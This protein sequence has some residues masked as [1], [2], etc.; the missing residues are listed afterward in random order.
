[1]DWYSLSS[2]VAVNKL[3]V[4]GGL[5]NKRI[6]ESQKKYG[7]NV[8]SKPKN[9]SFLKRLFSALGEPMILILILSAC[10]TFGVNLGRLLKTGNADFIEFFGI[11][12]A[13]SVSVCITL[14]MEGSSQKA[15]DALSKMYDKVNVKVLRDKN[16]KVIS[17]EDVVVGDLIELCAGDKIVADGRLIECT[18]FSVDESALTGESVPSRKDAVSVLP[19]GSHLAERKNMVYSGSFVT[20]G[21]AKYVVTGVGNSTEIGTIANEIGKKKEISSPLEQKL[22]KLGKTITLI[23]GLVSAFIFLISIT[24]LAVTKQLTFYNAQQVFISCIVLIV[25]AVPEGLPSIVA[26]SLALNM[27]KLAKSNALIKKLIATETTGAV[28]VICSDKTG[29]LTENKMRVSA[30]CTKECCFNKTENN[31]DVLYENFCINSTADLTI[32]GGV[33]KFVG[34]GSECALLSAY[35][36]STK[37]DYK[38]LRL[39][40]KII[41]RMPFSSEEKRMETLVSKNDY[42]RLYVKGAPEVILGRCGLSDSEIKVISDKIQDYEKQCKR[43]LCFAHMDGFDTTVGSKNLTFDGFAVISDNIRK[44]VFKAVKDAKKAGIEIKIL[45][46]DNIVTAIAIARE[47]GIILDDK[48]AVLASDIDKISDSELKRIL[49]NVKVIARS[50]PKTKLRVVKLLKELG[51]VVAV[52]GDGINDAPAIKQADVGICM[53]ITGSEITKEAS[54]VILLD[55]SFSTIISA[56]KFGRNVYENMQRFILFQLSVNVSALLIIVFSLL[57]GQNAPFNTLQLLWINVIMDGPPA[58][59]L[60]LEAVKPDILNRK[61]VRRDSPLVTSKML[62]RILLNSLFVATVTL[63]EYKYDFL[64]VGKGQVGTVVFTL[65]ITFQL[66]NAFNSRELGSKSIFT[67]LT[68]NKI[69]LATFC[70]TFILHVI[71]VTFFNK[72]FGVT[73]LPLLTWVKTVALSFSIVVISELYKI[74]FKKFL[75]KRVCFNYFRNKK[76]VK[77]IK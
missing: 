16:V 40:A 67:N 4:V 15:F 27:I 20:G 46:G 23:G 35:N 13:I 19:V 21:T 71:I 41:D 24:K 32:S 50:T 56:I 10:I 72:L 14:F 43:V 51:E 44:D 22:N 54:D 55:D 2:D 33:E 47:L 77:S 17:Q 60:G 76:G 62:V 59:T 36:L 28:S 9:K 69:M 64:N 53:G 5:D 73:P 49:P 11:I 34:S 7:K 25:A 48:D 66:F 37:K 38:Q 74:I 61:P 26:V 70:L 42:F 58:I 29:T 12:I 52:T 31:Y 45:T 57:M 68:K 3:S 1:M 39:S 75:S 65:F 18:E 63:L 30:I 8:L 6:L